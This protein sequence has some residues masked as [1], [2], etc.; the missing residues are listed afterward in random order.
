MDTNLDDGN[1]AMTL[2]ELLETACPVN[3][4]GETSIPML[5]EAIGVSD[6]AVYKWIA[7]D[8]IF[9][10]R[11]EEVVAIAEGRVTLEQFYPFIFKNSC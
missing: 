11:A 3:G 4:A 2:K 1:G 6:T 7:A 9:S 10:E 8:K 5:A